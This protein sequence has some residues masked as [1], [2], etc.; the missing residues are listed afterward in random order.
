MYDSYVKFLNK[1][2]KDNDIS[3]FKSNIDY[4]NFQDK[5][6]KMNQQKTI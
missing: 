3:G 2:L 6:S 4:K 5:I 1:I